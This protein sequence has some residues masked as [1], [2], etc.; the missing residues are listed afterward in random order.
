MALCLG[1]AISG[2]T[3]CLS[4]C[5]V[6]KDENLCEEVV[7]TATQIPL[8]YMLFFLWVP[9]CPPPF[10]PPPIQKFRKAFPR[11]QPGVG[12]AS[13]NQSF[14]EATDHT[15]RPVDVSCAPQWMPQLWQEEQAPA[16][17]TTRAVLT[18][19]FQTQRVSISTLRQMKIQLEHINQGKLA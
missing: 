11:Y 7:A 14:R 18:S 16:V 12:V 5:R 9:V 4:S 6:V 10:P 2:W 1:S 17:C 15:S 13:E 8:R 3:F 19:G